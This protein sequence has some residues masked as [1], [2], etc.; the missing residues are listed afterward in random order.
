M[1]DKY[2]SRN[3]PLLTILR[4]IREVGHYYAASVFYE[5]LRVE[6][7]LRVSPGEDFVSGVGFAFFKDNQE[8]SSIEVTPINDEKPEFEETFEIR[9]LNVTGELPCS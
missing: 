8:L 5:I 1:S 2:V 9:L 6:T 4:I 3:H 7:N